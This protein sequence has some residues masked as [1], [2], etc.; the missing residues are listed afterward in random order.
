MPLEERTQQAIRLEV[1]H[2]GICIES[3][4]PL[5]GL[6]EID[7]TNPSTGEVVKRYIKVFGAVSGYV[8]DLKWYSRSD[9][10]GRQYLG[11]TLKLEDE[12]GDVFELNLPHGK[13]PFQKFL[14]FAENINYALPVKFSS[15][16]KE[17]DVAFYASQYGENIKFKYTR[18][19][20]GDCPPAVLRKRLGKEEWDFADREEWLVDRLKTVVVPQIHE[21][22]KE[23]GSISKQDMASALHQVDADE[24]EWDDPSNAPQPQAK[25]AHVGGA[26]DPQQTRRKSGTLPGVETGHSDGRAY[27]DDDGEPF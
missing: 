5:E 16:K 19:N 22:A 10:N 14:S 11:F 8:T 12:A 4:E 13:Q 9:N 7:V 3:K 27:F 1:K 26:S 15:W 17:K 2:G 25:G 21:L 6:T 18:D 20:P 23:R 24:I